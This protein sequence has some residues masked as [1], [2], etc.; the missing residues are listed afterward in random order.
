MD[1]YLNINYNKNNTQYKVVMVP[2]HFFLA[3]PISDTEICL[4]ADTATDSD[5]RKH[6]QIYIIYSDVARFSM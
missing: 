6:I 2:Y 1:T 4:S 3:D 5:T